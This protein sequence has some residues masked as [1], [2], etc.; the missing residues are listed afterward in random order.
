MV[1]EPLFEYA[2][3][4]LTGYTVRNEPEDDDKVPVEEPE[5]ELSLT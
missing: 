4:H 1:T 5:E 2:G 3:M